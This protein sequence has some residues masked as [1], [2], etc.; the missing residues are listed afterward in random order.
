MRYKKENKD[1][2]PVEDDGETEPRGLVVVGASV[3]RV[4]FVCHGVHQG[5]VG[6]LIN[7]NS[8]SLATT[9]SRGLQTLQACTGLGSSLSRIL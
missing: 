7:N 5:R 9:E 8:L 6:P 2:K 3:H 1:M 4:C